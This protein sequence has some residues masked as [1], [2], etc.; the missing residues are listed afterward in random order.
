MTESAEGPASAMQYVEHEPGAW[1]LVR[2]DDRYY[3]EARYT[4]S[5]AVDDSALVAL[6][7]AEL[8]AYRAGGHEYLS[9]LARKIHRSAPY[10][11]GS[12]YYSRDLYRRGGEAARRY[13][14]EVSAAIAD[15]T[16][17]AEQRRAKRG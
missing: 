10:T 6:T 1:F 4:Y 16:W 11:E 9:Q 2:R 17:Q 14:G 3:L 15:H 8:E 12:S 7:A 5:A 13:R